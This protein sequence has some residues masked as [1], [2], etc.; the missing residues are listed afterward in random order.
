M[1]IKLIKHLIIRI[2]LFLLWIILGVLVSFLLVSHTDS[3]DT[4]IKI[5]FCCLGFA[6]LGTIALIIECIIL[7]NK[8]A[9]GK[10]NINIILVLLQFS[11]YLYLIFRFVLGAVFIIV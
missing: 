6:F 10:R 9:K 1:N 4:I 7:H 5:S 8:K 3:L 11:S 2:L